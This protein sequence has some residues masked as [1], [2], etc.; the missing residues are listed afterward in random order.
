MPAAYMA[1]KAGVKTATGRRYSMT[2]GSSCSEEP[3]RRASGSMKSSESTI[4]SDP[5]ITTAAT[6]IE[7]A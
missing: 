3:S 2:Y 7:N 6:L 4:S 5:L 1:M